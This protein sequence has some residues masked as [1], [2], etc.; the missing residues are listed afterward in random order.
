MAWCSVK[1][2]TGTTRL[3]SCMKF[4]IAYDRKD[5]GSCGNN[6]PWLSARYYKSNCLERQRKTR[7]QNSRSLA[8]IRNSIHSSRLRVDFW[9]GKVLQS[10]R[11]VGYIYLVLSIKKWF[12]YSLCHYRSILNH[13]HLTLPC[14][15][16]GLYAY[17]YNQ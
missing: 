15:S 8:G 14:T 7:N 5:Q 13:I 16:T 3:W 10:G 17:G 11:H 6:K 1:K 9:T 4:W 2:S 12:L